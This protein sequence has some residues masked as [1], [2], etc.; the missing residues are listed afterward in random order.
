[1]DE[2]MN[3]IMKKKAEFFKDKNLAVH[4]IKK[5]TYFYNGFITEIHSDFL[6]LI[7]AVDGEMP[8]FFAEIKEIRKR[9]EVENE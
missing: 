7:D 6:M 8:I 9:E 2:E 1:M 4:I 3:E 5:N